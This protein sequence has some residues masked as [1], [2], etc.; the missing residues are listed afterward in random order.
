MQW[1]DERYEGGLWILIDCLTGI[2]EAISNKILE[3]LVFADS[4]NKKSDI[5]SELAGVSV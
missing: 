5:G 2:V 1:Y 4:E 3:E